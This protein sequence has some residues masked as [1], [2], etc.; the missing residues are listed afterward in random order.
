MNAMRDVG[1][2]GERVRTGRRRDATRRDA[3]LETRRL[4]AD[5]VRRT[6][7]RSTRETHRNARFASVAHTSRMRRSA[8][9]LKRTYCVGIAPEGGVARLVPRR[10]R[11]RK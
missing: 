3:R 11:L 8:A 6:T 5:G 10:M 2:G 9:P 1:W 4:A 7:A